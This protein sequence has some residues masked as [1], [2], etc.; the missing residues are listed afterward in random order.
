[1]NN[2][3]SI[4]FA[5]LSLAFALLTV[6]F[7]IFIVVFAVGFTVCFIL[8][9]TFN[10]ISLMLSPVFIAVPLIIG[11]SPY[12]CVI[13]VILIIGSIVASELIRRKINFKG[14]VIASGT[15]TAFLS[16]LSAYGIVFIK[17]GTVS[18]DAIISLLLPLKEPFLESANKMF[19]QYA[20]LGINLNGLT[21]DGFY[22]VASELVKGIFITLLPGLLMMFSLVLAFVTIIIVKRILYK[23]NYETSLGLASDYTLSNVS[24]W[25]YIVTLFL[26]MLITQQVMLTAIVNFYLVIATLFFLA[27]ISAVAFMLRNSSVRPI[28]KSVIYVV[29]AFIILTGMVEVVVFLGVLFTIFNVRERYQTLFPKR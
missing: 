29:L 4:I 7:P 23:S 25:V 8:S 9:I 1:M 6:I 24:V 12:F 15:L 28:I 18:Y 3:K 22:K 16:L 21:V 20:A 27:G 26:K 17:A 13:P 5:I 14:V 10:R 2:K 11:L 19:E